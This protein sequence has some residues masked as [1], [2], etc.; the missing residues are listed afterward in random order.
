[1]N[2]LIELREH[3]VT[4]YP[5]EAI[6]DELG[7][8]LYLQYGSEIDVEFPSPKTDDQWRLKPKNWVGLLPVEENVTL[9]L[10]PKI[11]L[12]NLFALWEYAYRLK[13]FHIP[14]GITSSGSIP[15]FY[16]QLAKILAQKVNLR[17]KKGF[18]KS[19]I[20]RQ[21]KLP[22]VTGKLNLT[23]MM[24][25]PWEVDRECEYEEITGDNIH[26]RILIATL[27]GILRSGHLNEENI[28]TVK[29]A[30]KTLESSVT[31]KNIAPRDCVGQV[32]NSLNQDYQLLH[33]LCRFFLE[34]KGPNY[35][36]GSYKTIPFLVN[37]A[38]LFELFVAEWLQFHLPSRYTLQ[39]QESFAIGEENP[40]AFHI[41]LVIYDRLTGEV[42]A[43]L[44]TKYKSSG[45][46]QQS[47]FNQILS[48]AVSK[49]TGKGVLIYP[50]KIKPGIKY[51]VQDYEIRG[52]GFDI[53][54]DIEEG[55][56]ELLKTLLRFM[57]K[58]DVEVEILKDG[59]NTMK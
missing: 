28:P 24:E 39:A 40:M 17:G 53:Q 57:E 44:D 46:I 20:G 55:G 49:G 59:I 38:N 21:E 2:R 14:E 58:E 30:Y 43:V 8:L 45:S 9:S 36:S 19:Y 4:E 3:Q 48:Y 31:S 1:M 32:Y 51:E 23:H 50:Q 35:E 13:S 33:G 10:K 52:I 16:N 12:R 7:K 34:S 22:Y 27:Y 47:D 56:R 37:M 11:P 25:R 5:K 18:Y 54:G 15:E 26:N 29:L 42:K 6:S 41:D